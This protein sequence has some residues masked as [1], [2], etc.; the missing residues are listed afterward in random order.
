MILTRT[1][2]LKE[3][4]SKK[5]KITPF[6]NSNIGPAS[7]FLTLSDDF[8][9]FPKSHSITLS[10][11]TNAESFAVHKKLKSITLQ[12]G[13][14]VL[15]KTIEKIQMPEDL[16]GML[17]GRSRFARVGLTIDITAFFVQ[18]GVNNHQVFEIKNFSK[19]LITIKPGLRMAQLAFIRTEGKSKYQGKYKNQ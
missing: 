1:E 17:S 6:K 5:L 15:G 8:W 9:F 2:I 7:V 14:F 12:P 10:E 19:H 4:N 18:P 16:F 3:I 11:T 13:D